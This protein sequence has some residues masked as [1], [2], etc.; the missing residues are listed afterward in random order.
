[1]KSRFGELLVLLPSSSSGNLLGR[2]AAAEPVQTSSFKLLKSGDR[3]LNHRIQDCQS[4]AA[5]Q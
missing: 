2:N 1:M 4:Q 3:L 5:C